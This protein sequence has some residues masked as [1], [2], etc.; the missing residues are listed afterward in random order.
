LE[1]LKRQKRMKKSNPI[2]TEGTKTDSHEVIVDIF[3]LS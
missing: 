1:Y 3:S 2:T